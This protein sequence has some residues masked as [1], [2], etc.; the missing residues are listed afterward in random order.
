[1]VLD[2]V[3]A[4]VPL[5]GINALHFLDKAEIRPGEHVLVNGAGGSFGTFAVQLAKARGA[6]V[7][8]V[9]HGDKLEMLLSLGADHVIDS[10]REDFMENVGAYDVLFNMVMRCPYGRALRT[11]KPGG[12]YLLTNP[13]GLAQMLQAAWTTLVTDKKV[14]SE[15]AK[16]S[17]AELDRLRELCEAGGLRSVVDR[18]YPLE[19]VV[20]AHRHVESATVCRISSVADM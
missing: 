13:H 10:T 4:G 18:T 20:E 14:V 9:D 5:G 8:A 3:S 11:L 7:T 1:M 15:F 2:A 19:Q 17:T 6:E 12:R 16:E